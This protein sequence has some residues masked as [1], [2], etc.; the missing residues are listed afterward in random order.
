MASSRAAFEETYIN[1]F[2]ADPAPGPGAAPSGPTLSADDPIDAA[3]AKKY[4]KPLLPAADEPEFSKE[5]VPRGADL[6]TG[7]AL[8]DRFKM[9][10]KLTDEGKVNFLRERF[11][12]QNV[13]VH[14][15][16]EGNSTV[17]VRKPD[18]KG[19]AR[20][21]LVDP[22]GLDP[23]DVAGAVP[24]VAEALISIPLEA[25]GLLIMKSPAGAAAGAMIPNVLRQIASR[26]V[27]GDDELTAEQ[28]LK[29][30]GTSGALALAGG[31]VAKKAT[32]LWDKWLRPRNI[33]RQRIQKESFPEFV[34]EGERLAREAGVDLSFPQLTGSPTA[35][36]LESVLMGSAGVKSLAVK[37]DIRQAD[38]LWKYLDRAAGRIEEGAKDAE[39]IGK[40]MGQAAKTLIGKLEGPRLVNAAG[41]P[42]IRDAS[43]NIHKDIMGRIL[44]TAEATPDLVVQKLIAD[45]SSSRIKTAMQFLQKT[46]PN[47]ARRVRGRAVRELMEGAA[48]KGAGELALREARISPQ[49]FVELADS[50]GKSIEAILAGDPKALVQFKKGVRIAKRL[51]A[52]T[53]SAGGGDA[54]SAVAG[55]APASTSGVAARAATSASA[56]PA[57]KA[58]LLALSEFTTPEKLF[59]VM[60]DP[61]QAKLWMQ[62]IETGPARK[63]FQVLLGKLAALQARTPA[64]EAMTDWKQP[65]EN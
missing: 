27:G 21:H 10:V 32:A 28:R 6:E 60:S 5:G 62:M 34:E 50:Q 19:N 41:K 64:V 22:E 43:E 16:Q 4:G 53:P 8:S 23:G 51:A 9:G 37:R 25:A 26:T 57:V 29:M 13:H 3:I 38:Q 40:E 61:E 56:F 52:R 65:E 58:N 12:P 63:N 59:E 35:Q 47:L 20:W 24:D 39:S 54:L 2:G 45:P 11:K 44:G 1:L 15:D 49:Q 55:W 31:A 18:A 14:K 30:M 33:A 46:N 36:S 48:P 17:Y 7:I 42:L